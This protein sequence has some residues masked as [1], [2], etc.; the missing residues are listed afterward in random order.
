VALNFPS[1]FTAEFLRAHLHFVN[2][3]CMDL[4]YLFLRTFLA[5]G[6]VLLGYKV[7]GLA[8]ATLVA[9]APRCFCTRICF[10]GPS[11]R[12]I[13]CQSMEPE[14]GEGSLLV[15]SLHVSRLSRQVPPIQ[16]QPLHYRL[17]SRHH[18]GYP[19]PICRNGVNYW[20]NWWLR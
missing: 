4:V 6:L 10:E 5:V 20:E 18:Y 16:E 17:I 1:E 12:E 2:V 15:Q 9:L 11:L 14:A 19:F 8:V 13:V 7:V 3:V